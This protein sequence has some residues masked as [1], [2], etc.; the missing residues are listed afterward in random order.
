MVG[1]AAH[2]VADPE[3]RVDD[4]GLSRVLAGRG[5]VASLEGDLRRHRVMRCGEWVELARAAHE[6]QRLGVAARLRQ[7]MSEHGLWPAAAAI[8]SNRSPQRR[9]RGRPVPLELPAHLAERV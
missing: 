1:L 4:D 3:A 7:Q 8:E 5:I 9:L 6:W 2:H